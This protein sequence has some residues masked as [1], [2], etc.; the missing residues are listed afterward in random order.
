MQ[1]EVITIWIMVSVHNRKTTA[2]SSLHW[3]L[4]WVN[5]TIIS[6]S[7]GMKT[8]LLTTA[9]FKTNKPMGTQVGASTFAAH[10][11]WAL[12]LKMMQNS[13]PSVY[14]AAWVG[15]C[16]QNVTP[17]TRW[18]RRRTLWKNDKNGVFKKNKQTKKQT[19]NLICIQVSSGEMKLDG[20][21]TTG[22]VYWSLKGDKTNCI[23]QTEPR[24]QLSHTKWKR[25]QGK[26]RLA[27]VD[28]SGKVD[29][30]VVKQRGAWCWVRQILS[31]SHRS[32][33]ATRL[34]RDQQNEQRKS[35]M[36]R[37][38]VF[39]VWLYP[40]SFPS[41]CPRAPAGGGGAWERGPGCSIWSFHWA[42]QPTETMLK[43]SE[44]IAS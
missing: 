22:E 7:L 29:T 3:V 4:G 8:M 36:T 14:R 44:L 37:V 2:A 23:H 19:W 40:F 32:D 34:G 39:A 12:G 27:E 10:T 26:N 20:D 28:L 41:A 42:L 30:P 38:D 21:L 17:G 43:Q 1:R 33:K 15:Q 11:I 13:A 35:I 16:H 9:H 5:G 25:Q 6:S 18:G 24:K 31:K